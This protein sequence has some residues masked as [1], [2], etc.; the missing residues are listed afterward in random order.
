MHGGIIIGAAILLAMNFGTE[1]IMASSSIVTGGVTI[2]AATLVPLVTWC[3][4]GCPHPVP[5]S[6]PYLIGAGLVTA[7]HA[8]YNIVSAPKPEAVTPASLIKGIIEEAAKNPPRPEDPGQ[9]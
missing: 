6:V 1:T 5:E 2:S 9:L 8:I 3:M 7:G 4:N